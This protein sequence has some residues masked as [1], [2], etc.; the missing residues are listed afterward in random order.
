MLTNPKSEDHISYTILLSKNIWARPS[1]VSS[2]PSRPLELKEGRTTGSQD[3]RMSGK[4]NC[5]EK[6]KKIRD[7]YILTD[8]EHFDSNKHL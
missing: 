5:E 6:W 8:H 4:I 7:P 1:F 2:K 3:F